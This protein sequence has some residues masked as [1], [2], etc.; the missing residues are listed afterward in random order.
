MLKLMKNVVNEANVHLTGL[1]D[2]DPEMAIVSPRDQPEFMHNLLFRSSEESQ[3]K[4]R[5][6]NHKALQ[7]V[8]ASQ[9]FK[10]R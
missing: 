3:L 9:I 5:E 2:K 7:Q 10:E 8:F 6:L 1:V 4:A